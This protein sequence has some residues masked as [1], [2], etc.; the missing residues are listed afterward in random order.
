[1]QDERQPPHRR[2]CRR[3]VLAVLRE[4]LHG[5]ALAGWGGAVMPADMSLFLGPGP[6]GRRDDWDRLPG[7]E[8]YPPEA[9]NGWR[10]EPPGREFVR[11]APRQR[12]ARH[13]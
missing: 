7:D 13:D 11:N 2:R 1:M 12:K 6:F 10:A 8:E 9:G 5:C 3:M 4:V